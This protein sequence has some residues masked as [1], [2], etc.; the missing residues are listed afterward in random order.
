MKLAV[1]I[2]LIL[3]GI[4]WLVD[5]YPPMPFSHEQFGLYNHTIHRL[6]GIAF[7]IAAGVVY[8]KWQPKKN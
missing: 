6:M 8:W 3:L 7:F 4:Y 5:H 2:L 1:V